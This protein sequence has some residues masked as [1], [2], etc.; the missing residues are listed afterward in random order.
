MPSLLSSTFD[1]LAQAPTT[2]PAVAEPVSNFAQAAELAVIGMGL[3]VTMLA[4][5]A[6]LMS[7]AGA[8]ARK[9]FPADSNAPVAKAPAASP[10]PIAKSPVPSPS[11]PPAAK[12]D[13]IA[14]EIVAVITAAVAATV[15]RSFRIRSIT[16]QT[17][18]SPAWILQG[19]SRLLS[20][21]KL[22]KGSR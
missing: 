14:P 10:G 2:A 20:S 4:I 17:T 6:L 1:L 16:P 21:H 9:A 19:R 5:M 13:Q 7:L 8:W 18:Q 11:A 3:V 22:R 12:D 15:Q